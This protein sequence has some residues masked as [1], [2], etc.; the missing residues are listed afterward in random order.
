[1]AISRRLTGVMFAASAVCVA[2]IYYCQPLLSEIGRSLGVSDH[3]IGYLPMW[4]QAG[5][6][7]GMLLF[8]PLGDMFPRRKLIV[9]MSAA[10]GLTA[11]MM[12]GAPNLKL[13]N[14]AGFA[15]GLTGIVAHLIL[16]FAAKLAPPERRG[17]VVGT[18]LS[19]LLLGILLARVVSGFVGDLFGWRAMYTI[20]AAGMFIVAVG[21][22]YALPYDHPEPGLRYKELARSILHLTFTQPLLREAGIIGGLLFGAF[23]SFWATLVFRLAAPPYHYGP[24][25]AGFFGVIGAVGVL[26]AP[27]AGRLSDR[28]GPAYTVTLA[29]ITSIASYL[30]FAGA[31]QWLLGL[32]AGVI[33][34]DLGVQAGHVANQTRIY[35][36][37]PEARSR[38]NT[39]YMVTY[40]LGGALGSALGAWGWT[41]WGWAGVCAAGI[42]QL[43]VALAVRAWMHIHGTRVPVISDDA[44][45]A[46]RE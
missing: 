6:A 42:V 15:T 11:A 29:I 45:I 1:M 8:V 2:N 30:V 37:I 46:F 16:P 41:Q 21:L 27:L 38:L 43:L 10:A 25:V 33:V 22:R 44:A 19:G 34:M 17:H 39:V 28:K 40:F 5:V 9:I 35:A 24:R 32:I 18:V 3:A 36:L 23:S 13:V 26:F 4:T 7:L 31:G 14:A 20:A 12:A